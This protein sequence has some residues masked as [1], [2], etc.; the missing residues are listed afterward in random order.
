MQNT[1]KIT[2]SISNINI[3]HSNDWRMPS[4]VLTGT[5][6]Q[7]K[8]QCDIVLRA[9]LDLSELQMTRFNYLNFVFLF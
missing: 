8:Q 6:F 7:I 4:D 9:Y 2:F 5:R 3:Q 1:K